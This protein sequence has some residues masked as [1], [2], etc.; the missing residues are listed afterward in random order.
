MAEKLR[1][2]DKVFTS[3]RCECE[4]IHFIQH[5]AVFCVKGGVPMPGTWK[6]VSVLNSTNLLYFCVCL[7]GTRY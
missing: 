6:L 3:A 2:C 5:D 4:G 7:C 1:Q